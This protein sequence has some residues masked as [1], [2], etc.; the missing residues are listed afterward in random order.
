M[1]EKVRIRQT[2][3]LESE[4]PLGLIYDPP[5]PEQI[6]VIGDAERAVRIGRVFHELGFYCDREDE[7]WVAEDGGRAIGILI[8]RKGKGT[9]IRPWSRIAKALPALLRA[10][11]IAALPG[12]LW[13]GWK[14]SRLDFPVSDDSFHVAEIHVAPEARGLGLGARLL[15]CAEQRGAVLGC[16]SM[17]LTTPTTNPARRLYARSGYRVAGER[18]VPGYA[19]FTGSPGR[20]CMTKRIEPR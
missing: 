9:G 16:T 17:S 15:S 14:R 20:V 13:R 7:V 3:A 1:S 18:T 4:L 11:P 5:S 19:D 2:S 10:M 6:G 8:A 12:F